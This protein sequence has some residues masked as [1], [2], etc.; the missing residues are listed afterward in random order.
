L[1]RSELLHNWLRETL[2]DEAFT[3]APASA[4]ASFR[5]YFRV[6]TNTGPGS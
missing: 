6:T 3:L 5:R 4:D 1:D 2:G